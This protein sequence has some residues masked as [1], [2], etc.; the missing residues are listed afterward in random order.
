MIKYKVV[1]K[2]NSNLM[3]LIN[4][5]VKPFNKCFMDYYYT[6]IFGTI[7]TPHKNDKIDGYM[8]AHELTHLKDSK[9]YPILYELSYL[10]LL[11]AFF[12]FRS[13]WEKRGYKWNVMYY[14]KR[15]PLNLDYFRS[16]LGDIFCGSNYFYMHYSKKKINKWFDKIVKECNTTD[17]NK[18][19]DSFLSQ[20]KRVN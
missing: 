9:K 2:K 18:K 1:Y 5:F 12:T 3:K 6:T 17:Y 14:V 11:P 8:L 16:A 4:F 13:F 10:F 19:L 15:Y 7:Y 20:F